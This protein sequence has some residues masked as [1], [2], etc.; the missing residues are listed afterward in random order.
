VQL[1]PLARTLGFDLSL[2]EIDLGELLMKNILAKVTCL[3]AL[4]ILLGPSSTQAVTV[5]DDFSDLNDTSNPTWTHLTGDANSTG[6]GFDASSGAYRITAQ[7]NGIT[8]SGNQYGFAGAYTGASYTDVNVMADLVAP[9]TGL[10]FGV[11]ARLDGN[12]AL[13]GLKGYAYAFEQDL[14]AAPGVGEMVLYRITGLNINDIGNDGPAVR[15]VNLD[16][17]NKD[18]TMSLSII[19]STLSASVTEVGGP[20]VAFQQKTDATYASG[21]SGLFG[22]GARSTTLPITAPLDFTVDNFKTAT[23]PEPA[24]GLLAFA[25]AGG[26]IVV[27]RRFR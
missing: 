20:V 14:E 9:S 8:I 25:A 16:L 26:M 17:A 7:P 21:F 3:T 27:R 24:T 13:N 12:N 18:Y 2:N 19:G 5:T 22:L 1:P 4:F 15:F 6:Q 11:A 10:S 23:I